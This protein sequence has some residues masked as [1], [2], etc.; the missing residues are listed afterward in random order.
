M[1]TPD[2]FAAFESERTVIKPKP[3]TPVNAPAAS[4]APA[5]FF[6][7]TDPTPV[8]DLGELGLLNPLVSA[9]GKLLVLIGKLHNLVQPPNVP[10]LRASTAEAVNQFDQNARRAGVALPQGR[11]RHRVQPRRARRVPAAIGREQ[12][13]GTVRGRRED[14]ARAA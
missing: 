4:A 8:A 2:P 6:P 1:T 5:P 3:R 11:R 14:G 10:A 12:P 9:A 13:L 7:A